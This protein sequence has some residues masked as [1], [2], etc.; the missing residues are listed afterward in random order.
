MTT[1]TKETA[2]AKESKWNWRGLVERLAT[3]RTKAIGDYAELVERLAGGEEMAD[4]TV[5]ATLNKLG[6]SVYDLQADVATKA[7]RLAWAAEI[8]RLQVVAADGEKAEAEDTAIIAAHNAAVA[9]LAAETDAKRLPL[10]ARKQAGSSAT[11]RISDLNYKL[12]TGCPAHLLEQQT[13]IMSELREAVAA[14][15]RQDDYLSQW[16]TTWR[17]QADDA[18]DTPEGR[19]Q[20]EAA[21]AALAEQQR[22]RDEKAARV[23]DLQAQMA[24]IEAAKVKP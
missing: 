23:A 5:E 1:A 10:Q 4:A 9:K 22:Q 6:K 8:E 17:R 24:D 14:L 20:A 11:V 12:V 7:E 21:E 15:A 13:A 3:K 2:T 18:D 19:Q 16:R